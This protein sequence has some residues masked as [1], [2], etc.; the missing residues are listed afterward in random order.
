M[1]LA[2]SLW[3]REQKDSQHYPGGSVRQVLSVQ[4]Y[5]SPEKLIPQQRRQGLSGLYRPVSIASG[6]L[7]LAL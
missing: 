4:Q 2:C 5:F 1:P 3:T 7:I 6:C